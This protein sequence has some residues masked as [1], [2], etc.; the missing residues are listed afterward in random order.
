MEKFHFYVE[1]FHFTMWKN[2]TFRWNNSN[3]EK[4]HYGKIPLC[5]NC[6]QHQIAKI[7]N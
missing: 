1:K 3:M 4:F 6:E 5:N 7:K 2:S